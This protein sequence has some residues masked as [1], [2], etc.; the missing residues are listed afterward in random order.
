MRSFIPLVIFT[1]LIIYGCSS[2]N[3]L[4]ISPT[5]PSIQNPQSNALSANRHL[6]GFWQIAADPDAGTFEVTPLRAISMHLNAVPLLEPPAGL[7]IKISNVKFTDSICDV[8]V[9]LV[10]PYPGYTQY[11]G[12]DVA[13]I[14]ISKGTLGGFSDPSLVLAGEGETRLLNADGYTRWWNPTEFGITGQPIFRY[15]DGMLGTKHSTANFNCTL[16]GYKL[17]GDDLGKDADVLSLNPSN[18]LAFSPGFSNTRHYKI[19]F[20]QGVVFNYAVDANWEPPQGNPPFTPDQY[21]PE[22]N[23]P[24]AWAVSITELENSLWNDAGGSGGNL[25]LKIDVWD[26]YGADKNTVIVESPGSFNPV[27]VSNPTGG[28]E[29]FSTY[30]VDIVGATPK[31]GSIDLLISIENE[32]VGY[33]DAL[34]DHNITAYFMYKATVKGDTPAI[35]VITPNGG[36]VW[37]AKTLKNI[38]W[39]AP[40]SVQYVDI[41]YSKDDFG[42]DIQSIISSHPNTGSFQWQVAN[43]PSTTVKVKVRKAGGGLEDTSDNYFTIT[44]PKCNFGSTGWSLITK[45]NIN[46]Q[47]FGVGGI[48]VTRQDPV[49]RIIT[50][51]SPLIDSI[52]SILV[53][54]ASNPA[55]G[56]VASYDSGAQ[57]YNNGGNG[58]YVDSYSTPGIDRIFYS[59][60][61]AITGY[62]KRIDWNGSAFV[63]QQD[64][65]IP[66]TYGIWDLCFTPEG[67][68]YLFTSYGVS[69]ALYYYKKATGYTRTY[70]F[71]LPPGAFEFGSVGNFRDIVWSPVLNAI[72]ILV[73][74]NSVS[75]GRQLYALKPTGEVIFQDL[76]VF[77]T[78]NNF[79]TILAGMNIDLDDPECRI[80]T[81]AVNS[82]KRYFV[83]YS[84]DL[85][86]KKVYED[87]W[88]DSDSYGQTYGFCKGDIQNDGTLWATIAYPLWY[89]IFYKFSPPPDW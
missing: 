45:Y 31:P 73:Q 38:T 11:I 64:L 39:W 24:E 5:T 32:Q 71:N 1:A 26:H 28:G 59:G 12:F 80:V 74:N 13:G 67:D 22:A 35:K 66:D 37:E 54:N 21:A 79:P 81:Y 18:R 9:T 50:Q 55:G 83:R 70:L 44:K 75:S 25:S 89:S 15:K 33:V 87:I 76:N 69:P 41:L 10:H 88:T 85:T 47:V 56:I 14:F 58:I 57:I 63:N 4:P 7:R 86:E 62:F 49:Q 48:W 36:E 3:E 61:D 46:N 77:G 51:S 16:N 40:P 53:Y 68:I 43:D 65:Q 27:K 20:A 19:D 17:F 34:P 60:G 82:G 6:W 2:G 29:G 72:V 30:Q 52:R 78:T 8:D 42:S 23:R 84:G